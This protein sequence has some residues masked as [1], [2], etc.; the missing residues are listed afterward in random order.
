MSEPPDNGG[1]LRVWVEM[2][3]ADLRNAEHTLTLEHD[4][5]FNTICF[6]AQQCAEKYLKAL[7]IARSIDFP[8]THDLRLL[9]QIVESEANLPLP[10]ADL[11]P[12]NRYSVEVRYPGS[13][14]PIM[15]EEAEEAV[16]LAKA[17]R[18]AVRALL[19]ELVIE[20]D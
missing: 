13:W 8:K 2:A 12:L 10:I 3:E 16:A 19:P 18:S 15:R 17:I 1:W 11:L 6:H 20:P 9:L 4:C 5:P 7:L 14:E